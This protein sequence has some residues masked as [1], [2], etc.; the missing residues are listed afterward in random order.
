V[1]L[2][3]RAPQ[4]HQAVFGLATDAEEDE[5]EGGEVMEMGSTGGPLPR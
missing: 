3:S 4:N 2:R 5:G 1:A